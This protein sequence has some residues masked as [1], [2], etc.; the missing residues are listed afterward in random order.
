MKRD[1]EPA[2]GTVVETRRESAVDEHIYLHR[3]RGNHRRAHQAKHRTH[4]FIAP[5]EIGAV[6]VADA[7]QRRKLCSQLP[8]S[9]DERSNCQTG[10][11]TRAEMRIEPPANH[12]TADDGAEV[13]IA[14]CH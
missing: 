10:E 1:V 9:A 4:A 7:A 12:D 11:R 3:A 13:E 2:Y 8:H 5:F 6:F 14:R